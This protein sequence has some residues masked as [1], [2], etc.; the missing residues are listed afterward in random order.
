MSYPS[1]P[2]DPGAPDP[3]TQRPDPYV[4]PSGP[5][6]YPQPPYAQAPYTAPPAGVFPAY[7][8]AVPPQS[9]LAIAAMI[10]SLCGLV[11]CGLSGVVGLILG[12]V[13]LQQVRRTGARGRGMAITGIVVGAVFTVLFVLFVVLAVATGDDPVSSDDGTYAAATQVLTVVR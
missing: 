4:S 1:T 10:V 3:Y 6:S 9:G 11:T 8:G 7:P 13:A 2:P 12:I 5:S